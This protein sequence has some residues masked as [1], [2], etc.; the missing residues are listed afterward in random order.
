MRRFRISQSD[1][2]YSIAKNIRNRRS[3]V[4]VPVPTKP[5]ESPEAANIIIDSLKWYHQKAVIEVF[6]YCVM[7][8]HVHLVYRLGNDWSLSKVM[9]VL[10]QFTARRINELNQKSGSLWQ[11]GCH[12][13]RIRDWDDLGIRL[14]YLWNNPV[15]AGY[16]TEPEAWPFTGV[17]PDW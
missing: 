15:K 1:Q 13:H 9:K 3:S 12:E 2:I 8:D 14:R 6:G 5:E 4:L 17:K 10:C 7:P 11:T 16:V